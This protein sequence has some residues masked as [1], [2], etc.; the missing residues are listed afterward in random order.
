MNRVQR[1]LLDDTVPVYQQ[2]VRRLGVPIIVGVVVGIGLVG[3]TDGLD[4]SPVATIGPL[5]AVLTVWS[6]RELRWSKRQLR[7][8]KR[9]AEFAQMMS[10]YDEED[11]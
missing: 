2:V 5:V 11:E 3:L 9:D 4:V 7:A 8:I 10:R 1:F 6:W